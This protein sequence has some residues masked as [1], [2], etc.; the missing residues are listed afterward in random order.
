MIEAANAAR[1][2]AP[3]LIVFSR[4]NF[5]DFMLTDAPKETIGEAN[6]S[7]WSNEQIFVVWLKN[8][9]ALPTNCVLLI[10]DNHQSHLAYPIVK[11]AR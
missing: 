2:R 4:A 5:K 11:F 1:N 7:G 10:L 6:S 9:N 8:T 3:P